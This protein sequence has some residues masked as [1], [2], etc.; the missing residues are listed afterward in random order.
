MTLAICRRRR[1]QFNPNHIPYTLHPKGARQRRQI[2]KVMGDRSASALA[3]PRQTATTRAPM[4]LGNLPAPPHAVLRCVLRR[5]GD[6]VAQRCPARP[7]A[8]AAAGSRGRS[9]SCFLICE[10]RHPPHAASPHLHCVATKKV[11]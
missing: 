7:G 1:A 4:T 2:A 10:A 8:E 5:V 3:A 11:P 9:K 6:A